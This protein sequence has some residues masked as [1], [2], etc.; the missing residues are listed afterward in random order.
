MLVMSSVGQATNN[1][2]ICGLAL[3]DV[4]ERIFRKVTP[5][6]TLARLWRANMVLLMLT[7]FGSNAVTLVKLSVT[8]SDIHHPEALTRR[9]TA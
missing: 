7:D 8:S 1:E 5:K 6:S 9:S 2:S 3:W 4:A